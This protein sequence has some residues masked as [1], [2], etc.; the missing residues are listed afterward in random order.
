MATMAS[1]KNC[2]EWITLLKFADLFST[3]DT[4]RKWFETMLRPREEQA[5]D[6]F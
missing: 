6:G 3:E 4:A 2:R 5:C 1:G